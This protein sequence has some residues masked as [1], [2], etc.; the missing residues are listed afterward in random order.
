MGVGR[1][2]SHL[3]H[4]PGR[5]CRRMDANCNALHGIEL[6]GRKRT[7]LLHSCRAVRSAVEAVQAAQHMSAATMAEEKCVTSI[8]C[9]GAGT[10]AHVLN[11]QLLS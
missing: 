3:R 2:L 1:R 9:V 11:Q 4:L 10:D 8:P 5:V 6:V 7:C